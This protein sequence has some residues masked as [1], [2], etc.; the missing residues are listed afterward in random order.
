M[1]FSD[2]VEN[3]FNGQ[4]LLRFLKEQMPSCSNKRLKAFLE[5]GSVKINGMIE[6]FGSK[7]VFQG[8]L[9]QFVS[10]KIPI[11]S[12]ICILY[13]DDN[14]LAINKPVNFESSKLNLNRSFPSSYLVHRL[15]KNTTG[16]LLI[17]KNKNFQKYLEDLFRTKKIQKKYVAL[18]D[19]VLTK[20]HITIKSHLVRKKVYQ[21]QAIWGS[22]NSLAGLYAETHLKKLKI[23]DDF[24]L[25]E[26][27][28]ITG[29]TH[30]LRVHLKEL[31]HPILG[32]F[33]YCRKFRT[34][35]DVLSL[36]LHSSE[37]SFEHPI[38]NEHLTIKAPLPDAFSLI[39]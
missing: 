26:L 13:E 23:F 35:K 10:K 19:G 12:S 32:D 28:P 6:R 7:R 18:I 22:S 3:S 24:S 39:K 27:S 16:V 9:V 30:Q 31:G 34:T 25:V 38:T 4:S 37:V 36:C 8:D 20:D 29:R 14:F 2:L 33:Q 15:D 5:A 11:S 17:A 1:N 21:G